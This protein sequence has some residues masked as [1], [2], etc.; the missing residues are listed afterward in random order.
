MAW[1]SQGEKYTVR[2]QAHV[3]FSGVTHV[4]C[5]NSD[6]FIPERGPHF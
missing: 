5:F 4:F 1:P 2:T 3:S 6:L